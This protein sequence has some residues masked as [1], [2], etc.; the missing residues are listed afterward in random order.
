MVRGEVKI[1]VALSWTDWLIYIYSVFT[2][3]IGS[4]IY[5]HLKAFL[6]RKI[7]L[8]RSGHDLPSCNCNF[9][10]M[11]KRETDPR[12][13]WQTGKTCRR[14]RRKSDAYSSCSYDVEYP[15]EKPNKT[16]GGGRT[17]RPSTCLFPPMQGRP[18]E[19]YFTFCS[20]SWLQAAVV[21]LVVLRRSSCLT[22]TCE[23]VPPKI[24]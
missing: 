20:F 9:S 7:L 10:P 16:R 5:F 8:H 23:T 6:R 2:S 4:T 19:S 24:S 22:C 14:S 17:V 15:Q 21:M 1:L 18:A 3:K 11:A 12:N 13:R